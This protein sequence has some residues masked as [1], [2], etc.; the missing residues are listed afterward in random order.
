MKLEIKGKVYEGYY[1]KGLINPETGEPVVAFMRKNVGGRKPKPAFESP[2]KLMGLAKKYR[3]TCDELGR[4]LSIVGF[5]DYIDVSYQTFKNYR[6]NTEFAEVMYEIETKA[7]SKA[8]DICLDGKKNSSGAQF[9]M[10]HF[11]GI[12]K[13]K[14]SEENRPLGSISEDDLR[15]MIN[16]EN[17]KLI[18]KKNGE[19][20]IT[21]INE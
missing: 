21:D 11:H 19:I 4:P 6:K 14:E 15:N 3:E 12:G 9:V 2:D 20:T 17:E 13:D 1:P 7:L 16:K 5:C 10:K 18:E 8:V